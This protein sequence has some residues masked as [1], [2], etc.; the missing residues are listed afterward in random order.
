MLMNAA[1]CCLGGIAGIGNALA[2]ATMKHRTG[3][4]GYV[5]SMLD[6]TSM[7]AILGF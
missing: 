3:K 4:R 6:L 7:P 5:G 1:R 2:M